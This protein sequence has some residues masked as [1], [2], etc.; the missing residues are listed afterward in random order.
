MFN[1]IISTLSS[2]IGFIQLKLSDFGM[3]KIS[4]EETLKERF[5]SMETPRNV[6]Q[7]LNLLED[8]HFEYVNP[9]CP[10]YGSIRVNKQEYRERNPILGELGPTRIFM[11]R[12][13]CKS[14]G[15]KFVTQLDS[16]N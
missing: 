11:R 6:N 15:K 14:C 5:L 2:S 1:E 8:N 9:I 7:N 3:E 12:Y 16:V 4:F 10:Y 13:F